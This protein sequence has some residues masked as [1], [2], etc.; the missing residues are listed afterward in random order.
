MK[1][2]LI[3]TQDVVKIQTLSGFLGKLYA[4][5]YLHWL[6]LRLNLV[7]FSLK[8]FYQITLITSDCFKIKNQKI[9]YYGQKL[10]NLNYANNRQLYWQITTKLLNHL[11]QIK[12]GFMQFADIPLIKLLE[13][14]LATYLSY[15]YFIYA[16]LYQKLLQQIKPD[17]VITLGNS[18]H[19]QT[20]QFISQQKKIPTISFPVF[21]FNYLNQWLIQFFLKR[22]YRTKLELFTHQAKN[23]PPAKSKLRNAIFLSL[24]FFRHLK[25]LAP[26]YRFLAKQKENT[27]LVTD[28]KNLKPTLKN[29]QLSSANNLYLASFLSPRTLSDLSKYQSVSRA[30]YSQVKSQSLPITDLKS[31]FYHLSLKQSQPIITYGLVLS[32]LYLEAG[33]KLFQATKPKGVIVVSDVRFCELALSYL[34]KKHQVK[35]VLVSP[36]TLL[37]LAEL[38]PYNTTDK[39]AVVGDFA[40]KKLLNLGIDRKKIHIVGDPRLENYQALSAKL[41]KKA[42]YQKLR[43]KN[44]SKKIILL[45][46]FRPT[47]M[48]P[49]TEKQAFFQMAARAVKTIPNAVLVIKPH[50]TEKR[51][52]ILEE[53][54]Q[55]RIKDVIVSDNNQLE[56]IDLLN[57]SSAVLQTWSMTIFEAIMMNRPVIVIN[58]EKKDYNS[59]IPVLKPGGGIE[60][61]NQ[62][63]L[64]YWLRILIN[65]T[66]SKTKIQLKKAKQACTQFIKLPDGQV[67]QRV[68]KLFS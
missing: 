8:P 7:I 66:H 30:I 4:W 12:P 17:K 56:L 28:I 3:I 13:T 51:Y 23:P 49:K 25:T 20:A 15:H 11:T 29:L 32:R 14:R 18:P 50:P 26:L 36:N 65:P 46:S 44:L 33:E 40:R 21:S 47:W 42:V 53:I 24:D 38:N 43:L 2:L 5:L 68:A 37:A 39:V 19:E 48:I 64:N 22:E 31:F 55:W 10:A 41:D 59:F 58:P 34:A 6:K 27:W 67:A 57:T 52:R 63:D 45:I 54:K 1:H 35:S 62:K 9:L 16:D 61:T 60:V